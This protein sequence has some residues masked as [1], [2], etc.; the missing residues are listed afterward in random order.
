MVDRLVAIVTAQYAHVM[1]VALVEGDLDEVRKDV[2]A[3]PP[4]E[5]M[6][7]AQAKPLK[8]SIMTKA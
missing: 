8:S 7:A 6:G 3:I 2:A 1:V 4:W 5:A